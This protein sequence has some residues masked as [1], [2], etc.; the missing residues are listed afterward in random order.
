MEANYFFFPC[1]EGGKCSYPFLN[2]NI[3][4]VKTLRFFVVAIF[5]VEN[6]DIFSKNEYNPLFSTLIPYYYVLYN[7]IIVVIKFVECDKIFMIIAQQNIPV[8]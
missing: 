6:L 8:S 1:R 2:S 7:I 5:V 4:V 3:K